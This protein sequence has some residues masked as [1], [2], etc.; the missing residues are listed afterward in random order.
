MGS[1]WIS[2]RYWSNEPDGLDRSKARA[3]PVRTWAIIT[4]EGGCTDGD[5]GL[6]D[7]KG[8]KGKRI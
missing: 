8:W 4:L 7:Q 3:F 1:F 5:E 2:R 6:G